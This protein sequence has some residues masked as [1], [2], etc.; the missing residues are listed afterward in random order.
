MLV[1]Q[2]ARVDFDRAMKYVDATEDPI[3]QLQLLN[4]VADALDSIGSSG[5]RIK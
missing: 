3:S 1:N 4:N 5:A 2:M